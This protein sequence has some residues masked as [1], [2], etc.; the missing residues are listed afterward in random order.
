MV[1]TTVVNN[2]ESLFAGTAAALLI[3]GGINVLIFTHH[4]WS[5]WVGNFSIA[6]GLGLLIGMFGYPRP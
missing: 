1:R 3:D 2:R 5:V 4:D 6:V